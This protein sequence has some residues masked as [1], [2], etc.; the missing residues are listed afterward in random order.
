MGFI[1]IK[2]I[3][4]KWNWIRN[5]FVWPEYVLGNSFIWNLSVIFKW[6]PN[7]NDFFFLNFSRNNNLVLNIQKV[8]ILKKENS[9]EKKILKKKNSKQPPKD[10]IFSEM[11]KKLLKNSKDSNVFFLASCF[12]LIKNSDCNTWMYF[13]YRRSNDKNIAKRNRIA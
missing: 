9:Q 10:L 13:H 2:F 8:K 6:E 7:L 3:A 5:F 1:Y 11:K 12:D 4:W